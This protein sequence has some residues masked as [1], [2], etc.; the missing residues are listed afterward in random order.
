MSPNRKNTKCPINVE[1]D[2]MM[3]FL[4][5]YTKNV[6]FPVQMS[7]LWKE[8]KTRYETHRKVDTLRKLFSQKLAPN[9][10][11]T[12]TLDDQ[13]KLVILFATSTPMNLQ[14]LK[15]LVKLHNYPHKAISEFKIK[16]KPR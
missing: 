9:I 8:Y 7:L 1:T 4:A 14:Y 15:M 16:E 11:K 5:D 12:E 13:T 10:W 3:T 2:R 6:E